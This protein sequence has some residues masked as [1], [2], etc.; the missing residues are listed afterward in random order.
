MAVTEK[1]FT[2]F[3]FVLSE[4]ERRSCEVG[5][6]SGGLHLQRMRRAVSRDHGQPT[7]F[8]ARAEIVG[9]KTLTSMEYLRA[10][11]G[12]RLQGPRPKAISPAS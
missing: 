5:R 12:W 6:R 2:A 8:A 10:C 7:L 9:R 3:L 11:L 4:T 1:R